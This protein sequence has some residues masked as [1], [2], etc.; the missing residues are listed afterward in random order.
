M[1]NHRDH[2]RLQAGR[3]FDREVHGPW[4]FRLDPVA[5]TTQRVVGG[6]RRAC[7]AARMVS[8]GVGMWYSKPDPKW[9]EA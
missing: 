6:E 8:R 1:Q 3:A 5:E 7:S 9:V 2:G 4:R